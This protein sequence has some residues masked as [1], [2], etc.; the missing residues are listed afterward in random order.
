M[1]AED[2]E[3]RISFWFAGLLLFFFAARECAAGIGTVNQ[4]ALNPV[5]VFKVVDYCPADKLEFLQKS[6]VNAVQ[7]SD[8]V[9]VRLE[10]T[11]TKS[12]KQ[13]NVHTS[14]FV[15]ADPFTA[16]GLIR[17]LGYRPL[18]A[19]VP[20]GWRRNP[21][22]VAASAVFVRRSD[23]RFT[24]L[25]SL[26]G[27]EF[28]I[29]SLNDFP[30]QTLLAADAK[31]LGI[32]SS[33]LLKNA[34]EKFEPL[35]TTIEKFADG[36]GDAMIIPACALEGVDER[37]KTQLR[38]VEPRLYDGL[39]CMHSTQTSPGW[40]LLA[41]TKA[42]KEQADWAASRFLSQPDEGM[43][44]S[45]RSYDDPRRLIEIMRTGDESFFAKFR[46]VS[47]KSFV[48]DNIEYF[49]ALAVSVIAL[50]AALA[51]SVL[52][53]ARSRAEMLKTS[54]KLGNLE[55]ASIVGQMSSIVAHELKQP[56]FAI[57]NYASSLKRRRTNGR[58][59]DES[60]DWALERIVAE[61]MRANEI[62]EHVRS[63][64]KG[65]RAV[66]RSRGSLSRAVAQSVSEAASRLKFQGRIETDVE[67][68]I[69]AAFDLLEV[70]LI[71]RNLM[72]NAA[73]ALESIP[74]ALIRIS[75]RRRT[76][77]SGEAQIELEVV[78][79]GRKASRELIEKLGRPTTSSK[80]NGLGL[81]LSIVSSIVENWGGSIEFLPA[82]PSGLRVRIVLAE[83]QSC[84][85]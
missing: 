11:S 52:K 85:N 18:L 69:E 14:D 9:P 15:F 6:L 39:P 5:S 62:I 42:S 82:E 44:Y 43:K 64:A 67:P 83:Q 74:D 33:D 59:T 37:L 78:D 28:L 81:G 21:D 55:R 29:N 66:V 58:L 57:R 16:A 1:H 47:I 17:Y 26:I 54:E 76:N 22:S 80:T 75:L 48:Q 34:V 7:T 4:P 79:N 70:A 35:Q 32:S 65:G 51:L 12:L 10:A 71:L 53:L 49:M 63:Y 40:L 41:S 77:E 19:L 27:A 23:A 20:E 60:L 50:L 25:R 31:Q 46:R 13:E 84:S 72:T 68:G 2:L 8:F 73:Q 45:W 56:L 38:L 3:S 30:A 61:S 36:E 24:N